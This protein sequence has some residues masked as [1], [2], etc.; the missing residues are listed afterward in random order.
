MRIMQTLGRHGGAQ[1][2]IFQYKRASSGVTIDPSISRASGPSGP[3]PSI[4]ITTSEW[5]SILQ[6]IESA[7]LQTFRITA[8]SAGSPAQPSQALHTMIQAAVP[9]PAGGWNWDDSYKSY[10][11]RF[12][13]MNPPV[14]RPG[15]ILAPGVGQ[16]PTENASPAPGRPRPP[17]ILVHRL[18]RG[19][20]RAITC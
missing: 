13:S 15:R 16:S 4:H 3:K 8:P 12:R 17:S 20:P 1:E 9:S 6:A 19:E 7:P 14:R 11:G 18:R 5:T 2:G 10:S